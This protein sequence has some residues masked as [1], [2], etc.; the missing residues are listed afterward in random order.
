M[1]QP[2]FSIPIAD[3]DAGGRELTFPVRAAWLRGALEE[4][5]ATSA[6]PD[7]TLDVRVS[8]SGNDVVVNG[9]LTTD[10]KLA[11]ARC[12]NEFTLHI[13]Q[14]VT[15]LMVPAADVRGEEG[16]ADLSPDQLDVFPYSGDSVA[17]DDM[18]RDEIVLE[19]PMIPLCS[20]DC[21]GIDAPSAHAH[22]D[23]PAL[24]PRLAPLLRLKQMNL[25]KE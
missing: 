25:K 12:T 13:D 21:P 3:L 22:D 24:D 23:K 7:G 2:E 19:I 5:E 14:P 4:T 8:K 11:C 10:L 6:G 17:L 15:A 20:E 1:Q 9:H 18:I 16:E